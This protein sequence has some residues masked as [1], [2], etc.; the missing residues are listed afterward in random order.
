MRLAMSPE[1][2]KISSPSVLRSSRPTDSHLPV[3]SLGSLA[4]TLA[5][6]PGSSWLTIS[7]AGL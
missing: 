7:P 5:R 1:V 3:R 6:P 2:V 4:N